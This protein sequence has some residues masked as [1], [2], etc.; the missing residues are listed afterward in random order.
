MFQ[1]NSHCKVPTDT[2]VVWRYFDFAKFVSLL[3]RAELFFP[4]ASHLEDPFEGALP[5]PE[6]SSQH[7]AASEA[8]GSDLRFLRRNLIM[9]SSWHINSDE[10]F[11]M[12][13]LY[14]KSVEA[15]AI[16]T[17]IQRLKKSFAPEERYRICISQ[18]EYLDYTRESLR[19][20]HHLAPYLR[21]SKP[22]AYENE[23][24]AIVDLSER[25]ENSEHV[26]RD[27]SLMKAI[28]NHGVYVKVDLPTLL[29]RVYVSPTAGPWF[30]EL[31]KK[32]LHRFE[33]KVETCQSI[34]SNQ[35]VY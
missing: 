27:Q 7:Q 16:R 26:R 35:P 6:F 28:R 9:V 2:T 14:S 15:V 1:E 30:H 13:K 3:D 12:W 17:T 32:I 10:S 21:K 11:A 18:V 33:L 24:R 20:G 34:L 4:S 22:Y 19:D 29:D 8:A 23:V 5:F 31:V 25:I